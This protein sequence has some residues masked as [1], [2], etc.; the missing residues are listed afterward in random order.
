MRFFLNWLEAKACFNTVLICAVIA[1]LYACSA[2]P[3]EPR[4]V[5]IVKQPEDLGKV[6]NENILSIMA[7]VEQNAG[8]LN[9]SITLRLNSPLKK[10]YDEKQPQRTWSSEKEWDGLA[11]S[12]YNFISQCEYYGLF[13]ED[14]HWREL[15]YSFQRLKTDSASMMDAALWAR[16][17][18][19]LTDAFMQL[20]KDLRLG[21]L[22]KDSITTRKD[23][24][25]SDSV[26]NVLLQQAF[27]ERLITPVF[28]AQEPT[29]KSYR[30]LRN[31]LRGFVDSMD[32]TVYTYISYFPIEI[33]E[34]SARYR[35]ELQA[36]LFEGGYISFNNR[37]ADT[38]EL[39]EAVRKYQEEKDLKVDGK[40]GPMV[41]QSLN[42]NDREKFIRIAINL[43]R[44]KLMAD[45]LPA[46][47]A[48]VNIPA[49]RLKVW[50]EDTLRLESKVI[51][52]RPATRTPV[53]TSTLSNFV[54]FPQWTV[55]YS[56]VFNEM[57]PK[58]Q[59]NIAYLEKENLMV[60]D[61]NDSII[62]P[63]EINWFKLHKNNFPYLLKQ[64]QGDDNS[65]GVIK[66]NFNNKYSVYLHDTNARGLFSRTDR[67]LSHGC[68]RVQ[69]WKPLSEFLVQ[70]DTIKYRPDTL[71]AWM[72]R[73]EK[74]TV[75]FSKKTPLFIRYFTCEAKDSA[76]V[77]YNDIYAEDKIAR[78]KF[79][80]QRWQ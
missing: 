4:E 13:P 2:K 51:V 65:L 25:I 28:E 26:Y 3:P 64:R 47:Y 61:K 24:T 7:Y 46:S 43:D 27:N 21:R 20:I 22:E 42:N 45:S 37:V 55:P 77:F 44:Y 38:A 36:R 57:L 39:A 73:K 52:G 29:L 70:K 63:S 23:L 14:Y 6:V 59:K 58:I 80:V 17:D 19:M 9:D 50:E 35:Q 66:F 54:V 69:Q 60:V 32:R 71:A 1:G 76:V 67:A 10:W 62:D 16:T 68:V 53:L 30:E 12:L 72:H 34:D 78:Q 31:A 56:I 18:V 75:Y 48:W 15:R 49:F 11:D 41:V 74:H 33:P 5:E 8:K 79:F 40:A